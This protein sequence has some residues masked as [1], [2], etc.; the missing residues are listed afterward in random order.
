M[1]LLTKAARVLSEYSSRR[2]RRCSRDLID[3]TG[4]IFRTASTYLWYVTYIGYGRRR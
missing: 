2:E 3:M 1:A 4:I